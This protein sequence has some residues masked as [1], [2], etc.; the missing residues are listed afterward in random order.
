MKQNLTRGAAAAL[1]AV[2]LLLTAANI[3]AEEKEAAPPPAK[4]WKAEKI[5][6]KEIPKNVTDTVLKAL[7]GGGTITGAIKVTEDAKVVYKVGVY[8]GKVMV[9]TVDTAGKLL[10]WLHE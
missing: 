2:I 6:A 3:R 4:E 5:D 7:N 10:T 1:A 9:L 8:K